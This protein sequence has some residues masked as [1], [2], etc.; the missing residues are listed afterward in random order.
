MRSEPTPKTRRLVTL[1]DHQ[2]CV[3]CGRHLEGIRASIHHR[4][5]RSH[6]SPEEKH[7]AANLI[8]VCGSGTTGCHGE[9]HSHP[10]WAYDMGYLVRMGGHP[11]EVP[12]KTFREGWIRLNNDGS[13]QEVA[14]A[15]N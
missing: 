12:V 15:E 14:H 6:A 1:R 5:M 10:A 7:T 8:C 9:I 13:Y 3:V 11:T 2:Q 4:K